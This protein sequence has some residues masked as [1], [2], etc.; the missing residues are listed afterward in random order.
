[1]SVTVAGGT[2]QTVNVPAGGETYV[3]FPAGTIGG[4]VLVTVN[5]GPA[6]LASQRVEYYSTFNEVWAA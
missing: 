4:P 5:S 2:A 6:V 3:T 1:M